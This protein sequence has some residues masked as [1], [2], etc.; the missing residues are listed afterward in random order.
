MPKISKETRV[1]DERKVLEI[2]QSNAKGSIDDIAKKCRFSRQKVWQIIKKLENEKAIWGYAAIADDDSIGMK[3]YIMLFK[4]TTQPACKEMIDEIALK[5]LDDI[6]QDLNLRIENIDYV[7]GC[8]DGVLSFWTDS[9][10][11]AKKFIDRFSIHMQGL[12][13][14]TELLETIFP[15]RKQTIKNPHMKRLSE[16][17]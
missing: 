13:E 5:K 2:L 15:I 1:K 17:L 12:I 4:R 16:F 7:H 14:N 9:L 10:I 8:Y 11:N 6:F 3:H